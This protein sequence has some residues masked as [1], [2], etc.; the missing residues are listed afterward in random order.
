MKAAKLIINIGSHKQLNK[1]K[2]PVIPASE[3]V[4]IAQ[5]L[6]IGLG[7]PSN[8][9]RIKSGTTY[10]SQFFDCLKIK[11]LTRTDAFKSTH[12]AALRHF[13]YFIP[14]SSVPAQE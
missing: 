9:Y 5:C 8:G 12:I 2:K 3:P 10:F 13:Q 1:F 7:S 14:D 11:S 6:L 4:S